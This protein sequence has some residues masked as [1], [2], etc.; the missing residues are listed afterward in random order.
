MREI[1][2]CEEIQATEVPAC[3]IGQDIWQSTDRGVK[4][5]VGVHIGWCNME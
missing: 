1:Q 5:R 4:E 2:E 3:D